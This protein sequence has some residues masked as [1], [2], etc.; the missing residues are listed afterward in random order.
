[1]VKK[2]KRKLTAMGEVSLINW[3]IGKERGTIIYEV[4]R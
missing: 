3:C 1:M 2:V 4:G